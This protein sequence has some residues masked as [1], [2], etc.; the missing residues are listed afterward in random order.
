MPTLS[1]TNI[2][3]RQLGVSVRTRG[4]WWHWR[5]SA[6]TSPFAVA[7]HVLPCTRDRDLPAIQDAEIP[8]A[9]LV[10]GA[11]VIDGI[12]GPAGDFTPSAVLNAP[13]NYV[14]LL[15]APRGTLCWSH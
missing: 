8:A 10:P 3:S 4:G 14:D 13:S 1:Y 6:W 7:D 2:D 15:I 5:L 11:S 9:A 12:L